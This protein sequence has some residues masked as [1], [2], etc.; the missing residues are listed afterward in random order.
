MTTTNNSNN[1]KRDKTNHNIWA[2][3]HIHEMLHDWV[4]RS[5]VQMVH[6]HIP[7]MC[8]WLVREQWQMCAQANTHTHRHRIT[9]ATDRWFVACYHN[10]YLHSQSALGVRCTT[11][12]TVYDGPINIFSSQAATF[13]TAMP[14]D[15]WYIESDFLCDVQCAL[16]PPLRSVATEKLRQCLRACVSIWIHQLLVLL[17]LDWNSIHQQVKFQLSAPTLIFFFGF[18]LALCLTEW[19]EGGQ[20]SYRSKRKTHAKKRWRSSVVF[21]AVVSFVISI[22]P[23]VWSRK[24]TSNLHLLLECK[25]SAQRALE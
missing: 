13:V 18:L 25:L 10:I 22:V 24:K 23:S 8:L 16:S 7:C 9:I 15:A 21:F 2:W 17:L 4:S 1:I 12:V 5:L 20:Q 11:Y 19:T 6:I 14:T 3:A